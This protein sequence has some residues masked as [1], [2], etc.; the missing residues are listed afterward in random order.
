[1]NRRLDGFR[2]AGVIEVY[3]HLAQKGEGDIGQGAA[4]AGRKPKAHHP[5]VRDQ[6]PEPACHELGACEN[7]SI[8]INLSLVVRI[9]DANPKRM[10]GGHSHEL[11]VDRPPFP[12]SN[13]RAVGRKLLDCLADF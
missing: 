11:S 10:P 8:A 3:G 7:H 5:V 12:A 2:R 9:N 4:E 6:R 1:M 13:D